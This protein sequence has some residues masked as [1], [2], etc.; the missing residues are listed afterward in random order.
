MIDKNQ[1][2]AVIGASTD[3]KK[4]GYQVLKDLHDAGYKVIPI[5]PK[6]GEIL[7][8]KVYPDIKN[9]PEKIDVAIFVVPPAVTESILPQVKALAI[10]KV[11]LQPGSESAAAIKYCQANGLD[12][13][14]DACIMIERAN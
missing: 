4:Y 11:W 9:V 12:C 2:Y 7:G 1:T 14:H 3:E 10:K 5:N 13:A 8:L 6:G